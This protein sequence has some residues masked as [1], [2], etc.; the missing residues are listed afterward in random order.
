MLFVKQLRLGSIRHQF[1]FLGFCDEEVKKVRV[2]FF[3]CTDIVV[4]EGTFGLVKRTLIYKLLLITSINH[5]FRTFLLLIAVGTKTL[6]SRFVLLIKDR[7]N[8]F[9]FEVFDDPPRES[10]ISFK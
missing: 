6:I 8:L 5:R 4:K 10:A 9:I 3:E 1:A 7:R 2:G